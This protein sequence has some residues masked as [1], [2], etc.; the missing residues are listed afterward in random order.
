M[1]L[2]SLCAVVI[3]GSLVGLLTG[4]VP[5]LHVNTLA[6]MALGLAW[7]HPAAPLFVLAV[8]ITHT[9][10]AILPATYLGAP[11]SSTALATLPAHRMLRFGQAPTAVRTSAQASLLALLMVAGLAVPYRWLLDEPGRLASWMSD[12]TPW[13]LTA[14]ILVLVWQER[15]GGPRAMMWAAGLH[16]GAGLLGLAV[17]DHRF[18]GPLAGGSTLLPLLAGLFGAPTLVVAMRHAGDTPLQDPPTDLDP[19][20]RRRCGRATTIGVAAASITAVLPGVTAAVATAVARAGDAGA[21]DDAHPL[22]V[23]AT[24]SA[25]NTAHALFAL[26]VLMHLGT[27]RSGLGAYLETAWVTP[28]LW[29]MTTVAMGAGILGYLGTRALDPLFSVLLTR[30]PARPLSL[31][32]LAALVA[33]TGLLTGP[34]GTLLLAS[35]TALGLVPLAV[36]VRRVHLAGVLLVPILATRAGII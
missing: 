20:L 8:G 14:T 25:V 15:R 13:A 1:D 4:L 34:L 28:S 7:D 9:F 19:A 31:A 27:V 24:L 23:I 33:M 16:L 29:T 30:L 22:P 35:A 32:A 3:G 11:D 10:V 2:L 26:L 6:A 12:A 17:L 18:A 36:G 5:G 21:E